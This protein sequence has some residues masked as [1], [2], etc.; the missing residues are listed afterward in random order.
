MINL[1]KKIALVCFSILLCITI[2]ILNEYL[3]NDIIPSG[4]F[5]CGVDVGGLSREEAENEFK[6]IIENI[7]KKTLLLTF[8]NKTWIFRIYEHIDIDEKKSIDNIFTYIKKDNLLQRYF[9][10]QRLKNSPVYFEPVIIFNEDYLKT[11]FDD[12]NKEIMVE[13]VDASFKLENEI[14]TITN[15]INGRTI[16]EMELKREIVKA[17]YTDTKTILIPT[18]ELR[19]NNSKEKLQSMGIE[20]KIAEYSTEFNK[21]LKGRTEN[22]KLAAKKLNYHIIPHGQVFSFN[23]VVGERTKEKGYEE[24]AVFIN[25]EVVN[26]IGG[27]V[28]QVSSTI[29]NLALLIDLEIIERTNHSLPVSYVPLGRDATVNYN[30][31][32]LKF[33]NNTGG[34][35]LLITEV[36]DD[37]LTAKFFGSKKQYNYI[38]LF[39]ETIKTIS[40]PVNIQKD[41]N[42]YKGEVKIKQGSN[43]YQVKLW[44]EYINNRERGKKLISEDVYNPTPTIIYVGEK[45]DNHNSEVEIVDKTTSSFEDNE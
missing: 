7:M 1:K 35:L 28:C 32:D 42:L 16:D 9:L 19:S 14:L 38:E 2:T 43:G 18:K 24:A 8:E 11:T 15:D 44:K 45:T 34:Y 33:K 29:Y 12:I 5:F 13:P 40:P 41:N 10:Y 36:I 25:N 4:V 21:A 37:T 22:I 31:I 26:D 27:G 23:E 39:S 6:E 20:V 30:N 3:R 17:L